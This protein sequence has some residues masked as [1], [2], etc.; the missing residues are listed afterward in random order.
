[1]TF[2]LGTTL[3]WWILKVWEL[4]DCNLNL[5]IVD[6]DD[7]ISIK[8]LDETILDVAPSPDTV[9]PYCQVEDDI[10]QE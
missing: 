5:S 4:N 1:M 9:N 3:S 6:W 8:T 7:S 10:D 2:N